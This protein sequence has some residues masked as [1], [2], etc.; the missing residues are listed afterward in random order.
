MRAEQA[1]CLPHAGALQ[2]APV[3]L[4][5]RKRNKLAKQQ[6]LEQAAHAAP[7]QPPSKPVGIAPDD[8]PMPEDP[9]ATG[10]DQHLNGVA[11]DDFVLQMPALAQEDASVMEGSLAELQQLQQ[12]LAQAQEQQV[13]LPGKAA[14][15]QQQQLP[16]AL[17]LHLSARNQQE[18]PVVEGSLAQLQQLQQQ[19]AQAHQQHQPP[20]G[21]TQQRPP[22]QRQALTQHPQQSS[23]DHQQDLSQQLLEPPLTT[24]QEQEDLVEHRKLKQKHFSQVCCGGVCTPCATSIILYIT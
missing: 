10:S 18:E 6:V 15:Q 24:Q 8:S 5:R 3:Y 21:H 22:Q 12:R 11:H 14:Q 9:G 19:L 20:E 2:P 7:S 17:S 13:H 1:A 23:P 4:S 16:D